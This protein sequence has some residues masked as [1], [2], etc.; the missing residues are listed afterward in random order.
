MDQFHNNYHY[1]EERDSQT[2]ERDSQ[3]EERYSSKDTS[4]FYVETMRVP[5]PQEDFRRNISV[6]NATIVDI[7]RESGT[8]FVTIEYRERP[9]REPGRDGRDGRRDN[10]RDRDRE[11]GRGPQTQTV[12]LVVDR[13][14][15]VFNEQGREINPRE[16]RRGM[17]VDA[18]FSSAWTRS[19]PPQAQAFLIRIVRQEQRNQTTTGRIIEVNNRNNYILVFSLNQSVIRFNVTDSTVIRDLFGRRIPLRELRGG[20]RVRVTH[21]DFMTASIPPQTPAIE[22]IVI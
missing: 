9:T 14:T 12:R 22:I 10:D 15:R 21:P 20:M 1:F 19:I 16:L 18:T 5:N 8:L 6:R 7:A 3:T 4:D 17:I 11:P 2:D 13:Q